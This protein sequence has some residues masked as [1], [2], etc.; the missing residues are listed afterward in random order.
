MAKNLLLGAGLGA[1]TGVKAAAKSIN[2]LI[3]C[4]RNQTCL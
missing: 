2:L 3:C 4:L 1:S